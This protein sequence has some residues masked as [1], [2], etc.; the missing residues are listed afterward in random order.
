MGGLYHRYYTLACVAKHLDDALVVQGVA[1]IAYCTTARNSYLN[2]YKILRS[3]ISL[4]NIY[5]G[6]YKFWSIE[7]DHA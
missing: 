3:H 2:S 6:L 5:V 4:S 1:D 7:I